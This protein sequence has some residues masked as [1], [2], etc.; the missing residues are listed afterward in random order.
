M[1]V[2]LQKKKK[3]KLLEISNYLIEMIVWFDKNFTL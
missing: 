1:E 2:I 3:I